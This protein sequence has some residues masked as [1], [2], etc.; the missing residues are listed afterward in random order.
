MKL[1]QNVL[2]RRVKLSSLARGTWIE[3]INPAP[4]KIGDA[5]SL[6]RGTWIEIYSLAMPRLYVT[7]S[8]L[9]R[10][11][12]IEMQFPPCPSC[13]P[14]SRPSQEGRGLKSSISFQI[15]RAPLS[16]LARGTWIEIA[17]AMELS[18]H[19]TSRP[20]QE[21]RGLKSKHSK[22]K[23]STASRPSQEG[24][25]LKCSQWYILFPF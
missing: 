22:L 23:A 6:A 18:N 12:W 10:G 13:T 11:T 3:I 8:S 24:R 17:R 16:S 25:G 2:K 9:A 4:I 19:I 15:F 14:D 1:Y 7:S 20:S 21:G 5:S